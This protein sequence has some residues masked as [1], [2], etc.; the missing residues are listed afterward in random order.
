MI[1]CRAGFE[2]SQRVGNFFERPESA[3]EIERP[4]GVVPGVASRGTQRLHLQELDTGHG[5]GL[6]VFE[7]DAAWPYQ[8]RGDGGRA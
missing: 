6:V 5:K 4:G 2:G 3:G 7:Y 8:R 1:S